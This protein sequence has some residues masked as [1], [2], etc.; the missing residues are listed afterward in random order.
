MRARANIY[1]VSKHIARTLKCVQQTCG[2]KMYENLLQ[3]KYGY[4]VYKMQ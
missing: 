1:Y 3:L 4:Y 2:T